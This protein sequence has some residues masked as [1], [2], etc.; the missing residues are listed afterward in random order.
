[1]TKMNNLKKTMLSDKND[2]LT[3]I[4]KTGEK[5]NAV[6]KEEVAEVPKPEYTCIC[7]IERTPR[8]VGGEDV[9]RGKYPWIAYL[10]TWKDNVNSIIRPHCGATLIN[11][12]W[13]I[14]AAH[15]I[16]IQEP[17]TA[18]VLGDKLDPVLEW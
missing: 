6:C 14:T 11:S 17:V 8:I 16:K 5:I 13:A 2:I 18:I 9:P 1:M 7:G 15:C 10:V 4:R 3:A 12:R